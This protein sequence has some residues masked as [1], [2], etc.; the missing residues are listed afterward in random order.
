MLA[1]RF[2]TILT[3]SAALAAC[4]G[5]GGGSQS[6]LP[7]PQWSQFRNDSTRTGAFG[8]GLLLNPGALRFVAVDDGDRP[9]PVPGSPAVGADGTIYA[10]SLGGTIKAFA[11]DDLTTRWSASSCPACCPTGAPVG[12]DPSLG[13]MVSSPALFRDF[14]DNTNLLI[15]DLGGRVY[16][17]TFIEEDDNPAPACV[18]CFAPDLSADLPPGATASFRSSP[19]VTFNAVTGSLA[20]ILIGAEIRSNPAGEPD[21]GKLYAI[22]ADGTPRWQYPARGQG[23]VGPVSASPSLGLGQSVVFA[24]G[25]DVLYILTRN[26]ALRRQVSVAGMA[27]G[28]GFLQPSVV[29]SASLLVGTSL[30][31]VYAFN[32]DGTFRWSTRLENRSF[33]GSLAVGIKSDPTPTPEPTGAEGT[34]TETPT[35]DPNVPTPTPS[36]TPTTSFEFSTVVGVTGGGEV[37]FLDSNT[38]EVV[39]AGYPGTPPEAGVRVLGSPALSFDALVAYAS[40]DGSIYNVDSGSGQPPRFCVGAGSTICSTDADCPDD[41]RCDEPVWPVRIPARC[42]AGANA[43]AICTADAD[44]PGA[45]CRRALIRSSPAIDDR[46]N[47]IVGADD[48]YLYLVGATGTPARTATPTPT[49]AAAR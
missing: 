2:V 15:A 43:G 35:P 9:Q 13:P 27:A 22:N 38:G 29:S 1:R 14:D 45:T 4:G 33:L 37:V 49:P 39:Q 19:T 31:D 44:C 17:F 47:I 21:A 25:N 16:R 26:G 12:C 41:D 24:D 6:T 30:G 18:A 32:Q 46:G 28:D 8:G 11:A 3:C 10:A 20:A 48:G 23:V 36:P 5:G 42:S 7:S 40:D 34:P